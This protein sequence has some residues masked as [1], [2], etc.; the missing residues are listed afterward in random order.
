MFYIKTFPR[1]MGQKPSPFSSRFAAG[2][3]KPSGKDPQVK[4]AKI[5][6]MTTRRKN[7]SDGAH[8]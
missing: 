7:A 5:D 8:A 4:S 3:G 6:E 2:P 1:K